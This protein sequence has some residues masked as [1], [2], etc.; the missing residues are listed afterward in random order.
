MKKAT[1]AGIGC[2]ACAPGRA[3][4]LVRK[5][6]TI[7]AGLRGVVLLVLLAAAAAP[8][9]AQNATLVSIGTPRGVKQAFIL[10]KPAKPAASVILFAG[11][12]GAL[13]LKSA[14]AMKWGAGNFLVRS[15]EN[16][17]ARNLMVAVIDAPS[18]RQE[19]MNA[20]FRMSRAHAQDIGAVAA[21]LKTQADVPVWLVGTSMGTF[22]AAE[23]A[24]AAGNVNG[25]V[26]T[27][28]ITR[29]KPDWKIAQSHRDGVASMALEKVAVPALI[30]SHA[31]DGC[32]ITPA[33]D[34]GKL[35]KRLQKAQP[36][37]VVLL[38]GGDAPRS[39]PCEAMS[40]HGF[41][42]IEDK[43]VD[44][45]AKFIATNSK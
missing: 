45:I 41:L 5:G 39:V 7:G 36:V 6:T 26:L 13:R 22:S 29:A 32:D 11:G 24:I 44:A 38:E 16:F 27:S 43:A 14:S 10:I 8:A 2:A 37:D 28:T 9:A 21:Y 34:A 3:R 33:A 15:R 31:Q 17:A 25:L 19:G 1:I 4:S 40:Q 35:R 18:D 20:I 12:H 30:V 23:G 42:G